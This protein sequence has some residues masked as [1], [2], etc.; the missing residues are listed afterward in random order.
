MIKKNCIVICLLVVLAMMISL[1]GCQSGATQSE[2][3][4]SAAPSVTTSAATESST[5]VSAATE[6]STAKKSYKVGVAQTSINHPFW[7]AFVKGLQDTAK[8][9]GMDLDIQNGQDDPIT[10]TKQIE[11]FIAQKKDMIIV[12]ACSVDSLV[13]AVKECNAAK[14]PVLTINR[15]LGDG[16]E[17]VSYVGCDDEKG[18]Q[19]QGKAAQDMLGGKGNILLVQGSAGASDTTMRTKGFEDYIAANCPDI[20]IAAKQNCD[21]DSNKTMNFIQNALMRFKKGEI[22][23]IVAQG[24]YDAIAVVKQIKETGRTELLGKI[25][26]FDYPKA[27]QDAITAGDLY[28]TIDQDPVLEAKLGVEAAFKSLNGEKVENPIYIDLPI[29]TKDNASTITAAWVD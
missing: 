26:A 11:T 2:Q 23:G 13:P 12:M 7:V 16:A 9:Y 28:A 19:L 3:A 5:A 20:K 1:T 25:I 18:G 8:Q 24:P 10:Q 6:S 17:I 27:V 21:H 14:I 4:S 22:D 29:V 15:V